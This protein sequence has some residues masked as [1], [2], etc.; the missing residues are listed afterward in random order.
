MSSFVS[1]KKKSRENEGEYRLLCSLLW[2]GCEDRKSLP[3]HKA[4]LNGGLVDVQGIAP[5]TEHHKTYHSKQ[6]YDKMFVAGN[7]NVGIDINKNKEESDSKW[8]VSGYIGTWTTWHH[9]GGNYS[10]SDGAIDHIFVYGDTAN[11][12]ELKMF[13][14]V[15]SKIALIASDHCPLICDFNLK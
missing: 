11:K 7:K 6:G 3:F 15:A 14:I 13:D 12:L 5:R 9:P 10:G 2:R 8:I 4:L 1:R